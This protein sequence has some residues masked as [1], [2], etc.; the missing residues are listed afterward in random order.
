MAFLKTE[1]R[2]RVAILTMNKPEARNALSTEDECIEF[3]E[4][5]ETAN[6]DASLSCVI[7]TGAG[8]CFSAGGD[9]R[10]M[11]ARTGLSAGDPPMLRAR[12]RRGVQRL[13]RALYNLEM[14]AIAAVNGPAAGA[15]CD[16]ACFCDIRLAAAEARFAESFVKVGLIP[17]DGGA[18]ILQRTVG[19]SKAAEMTFTGE[20][21]G[22]EEALRVGLVS[23][24]VQ[25]ER[26]LDAAMEL[27]GRIVV[28]PPDALRA[29][30]RLM[31]E[32]QH[33]SFETHLEAAAHVQAR[34]HHSAEHEEAVAAF[35]DKRPADFSDLGSK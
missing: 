22:A 35:L 9:L 27:A 14:P 8:D 23:S 10:A 16:I 31:R 32:A 1:R 18:W 15:G 12:Y 26:L 5:C 29:A 21:I 3:A 13:V 30:K 4:A 34:A 20:A 2:G 7:L 6:T 24:V 17:G 25:R 19:R 33:L 11:R 28:N